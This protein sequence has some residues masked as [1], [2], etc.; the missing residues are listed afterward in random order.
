MKFPLPYVPTTTYK[1]GNG[2]GGN[3]DKVRKGLKRVLYAKAD[4]GSESEPSSAV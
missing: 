2:F 4:W 3:R 1:G